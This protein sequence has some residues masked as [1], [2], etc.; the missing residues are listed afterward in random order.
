MKL[1]DGGKDAKG[2]CL[3]KCHTRSVRVGKCVDRLIFE[4]PLLK[5]NGASVL[6]QNP[7]AIHI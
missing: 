5:L 7:I 4:R 3:L 6:E 1:S 2:L